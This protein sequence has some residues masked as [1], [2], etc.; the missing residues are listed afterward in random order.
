M[1][2]ERR[3]CRAP[4]RG[5][6]RRYQE[7]SGAT[8]TRGAWV[9]PTRTTRT[10]GLFHVGLSCLHLLLLPAC[11]TPDC[12]NVGPQ[13]PSFRGST[14]TSDQA[15]D[16]CTPAPRPFLPVRIG[17]SLCCE[18]SKWKDVF[19]F[20][21]TKEIKRVKHL[22]WFFFFFFCRGVQSMNGFPFFL[23]PDNIYCVSALLW[24]QG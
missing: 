10:A 18:I 2:S 7:D 17:L 11:V 8:P 19:V 6:G 3:G 1:C 20:L 15:V 21:S 13:A 16:L 9:P 22:W 24:I 4:R 5:N 12:W 23:I 14:A